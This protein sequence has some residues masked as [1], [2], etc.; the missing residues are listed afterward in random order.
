MA[1]STIVPQIPLRKDGPLVSRIIYGTWHLTGVGNDTSLATAENVLERIRACL[2]CGITTFDLSDLY[3]FYEFERLFGDALKLE[4]GIRRRIQMYVKALLLLLFPSLRVEVFIHDLNFLSITKTDIVKP[5]AVKPN[6]YIKHYNTDEDYILSQV[7]KSLENLG[8]DYIDILLLHR[9]DMLMDADEVA[10]AFTQ[11]YAENKVRHFG[12][13]NFTLEHFKLLQSRL[14]FPLVTNQFEISIFEM[15]ALTDDRLDFFQRK[16]IAPMAYSPLGSGRLF[17]KDTSDPQTL[18]L[19]HTLASIAS[20]LG[21]DVTIDQVCYAWLLRHPA[22]ICPVIGTTS[23]ERIR[24]AAASVKI[25][26]DRQ[27]WTEIWVASAGTM[28]P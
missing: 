4:P 20:R 26:L 24:K 13:S 19:Q 6:V 8:T 18:R 22:R 1:P 2:E 25:T 9:Q 21:R 11:L 14:E 12:G 28:V 10:R 16:R 3:G 17:K 5:C 7:N 27:Q 23:V 15:S